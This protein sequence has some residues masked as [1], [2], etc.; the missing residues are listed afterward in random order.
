MDGG[1]PVIMETLFGFVNEGMAL[2][3]GA[4]KP[5]SVNDWRVGRIPDLMPSSRYSGSKPSMQTTTV[6][7]LGRA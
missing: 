2:F 5:F 3:A 7:C 4:W 6:G 1:A